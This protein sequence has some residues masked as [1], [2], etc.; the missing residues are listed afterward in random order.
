MQYTA[1]WRALFET[2]APIE[3]ALGPAYRLLLR[4][5]RTDPSA[6]NGPGHTR[7]A[8]KTAS[9][10]IPLPLSAEELDSLLRA[11]V[12]EIPDGVI[13]AIN[14]RPEPLGNAGPEIAEP[15]GVLSGMISRQ[16]R[17]RRIRRD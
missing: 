3:R 15:L 11:Y 17:V 2:F 14:V 12:A 13:R 16:P 10:V 6:E 8:S 4:A 9:Q 1:A 5:L 7:V